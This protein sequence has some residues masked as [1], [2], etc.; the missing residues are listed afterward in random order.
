[1]GVTR[2]RV[3]ITV[4]GVVALA[5]VVVAGVALTHRHRHG[6]EGARYRNAALSPAERVADLLPRMSLDDK[7]GQMVQ[8]ERGE[9]GPGDVESDRLGSVLSG[10]G[11]APDPD[12]PAGWADMYD[13]Y[14]RAAL[15]TPLGIPILYGLDAVHGDNNVPGSTIFP[16][17]IGLGASRDPALVQQV[18]RATAEEVTGAGLDWTFAPC[19]CVARD[20]R[21]GRTY[22]SFGE[23]P[24]LV[25]SMTT[26][27]TG[28]QGDTLGGPASIL[29]TAK[30]YVG[31]GGTT[32]GTDQGNTQLS[33]AQLRAI[34]LPGFQAAIQRHVGSIMVSFSSWNGVKLSSSRYLL[35]D[36]LKNELGFSGFLVSDWAAVDQLDGDDGFTAE[37]I[38]QGVTAGLDMLMV[39]SSTAPSWRCSSRTSGTAR[40]S[41]PGST[42]RYAGSC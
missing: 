42:T 12:T 38:A 25:S 28:F 2:R 37:E 27:V 14:Q 40:S 4:A 18:G 5:L 26:I 16:H 11:S 35:T 13:A 10:G 30:H 33:E 22:E 20:D 6:T 23:T 17:N 7:L 31:D 36:V 41:S 21:W 29:A 24:E 15:A 9:V 19:L 8:G 32:N 39:P 34:H 3:G 1:M